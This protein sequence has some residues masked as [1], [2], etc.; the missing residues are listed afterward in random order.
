MSLGNDFD[1]EEKLMVLNRSNNK[2]LITPA[3]KVLESI[4]IHSNDICNVFFL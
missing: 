2:D 3:L 4:L 1:F